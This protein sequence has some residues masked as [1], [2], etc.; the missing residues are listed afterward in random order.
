VTRFAFT[1]PQAQQLTTNS[2]A[3][4][5][6]PDGTRI[7]YA[8]DG[9]LFMRALSEFESRPIPGAEEASTAAFSPDGQSLVFYSTTSRLIKRTAITGGTGVP[10]GRV[11]A[12]A[13]GSIVW[14]RTGIVY[15][16][17]ARGIM[18]AADRG[19]D[20]EVLVDLS[21][22]EDVAY[23]PQLLP[24]D[25]TLLFTMVKRATAAI[26][27]WETK[28][29]AQSIRTGAR[30]TVVDV[31]SDARYVATGH[32]VYWANGSIFAAPFDLTTL[33]VTG[34]TLP[35][36]EGVRVGATSAGRP[37]HFAI[38]QSGSLVYLP[39]PASAEQQQLMLFDRSGNA[40]A[41]KLP[42]SSYEFPRASPDG[43]RIAFGTVE[44]RKA[45][46]WIY[47]LA[48]T[49]VPQR[50]TFAGDG[51]NRFPVWSADGTHVAFQSDR[52]GDLAVFW[53]SADG[54]TPAVRLTRP[55]PGTVHVPE[56]AANGTLL[57]SATKDSKWSLWTL[58]L[59]TRKATPFGDVKDLPFPPDAMFSP[60]GRW[61]AYQVGQSDR[62]DE[63]ITY[64]Q[65]F[66]PTGTRA[67]VA[68]GGR[69]LW[70]RDGKEIFLIPALARLNVVAVKT[71]PTPTFKAPVALRRGFGAATPSLPRTFDAMP[72]GRILG[73]GTSDRVG[74]EQQV[75]VVVNWTE[76]LKQRVPVK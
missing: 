34:A 14:T 49:N 9:G 35:L 44:A 16:D 24:E 22:S 62:T 3:V 69:P 4:A 13:P 59:T 60:D 73:I 58:S 67:Q 5:I 75:R 17:P 38:S 47:E 52:G 63:A 27:Q 36:V 23:S 57:F 7:V 45:I 26:G 18:R 64:I 53:Q 61:V 21:K 29:V 25:D 66:P 20:P 6:S 71:D 50:L 37:A 11:D 2:R 55:E 8:A 54:A 15:S 70:S 40:E 33:A 46:V 31:G 30:K 28:V 32:I 10:I 1:L 74:A 48:G 72:D 41:I 43:T 12:S 42:R 68:G 19:G 65:P 56:S 39:G 51:S 76:E